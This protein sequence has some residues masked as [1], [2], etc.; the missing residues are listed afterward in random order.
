M[1]QSGLILLVY[2]SFAASAAVQ[3]GR[4]DPTCGVTGYDAG[5]EGYY[6]GTQGTYSTCSKKCLKDPKNCKSFSFGNKEC[7]LYDVV[8]AGNLAP[9]ADSP[10]TF[11]D[12]LCVAA[13][14]T[15]ST[16][17]TTT[18]PKQ[19][20]TTSSSNK[21][22]VTSSKSSSTTIKSTT[23]NGMLTTA[24]SS[25][26]TVVK[27]TSSS[28]STAAFSVSA[29]TAP[30]GPI[31][32]FTVSNFKWINST[33]NAD[34]AGAGP[35]VGDGTGCLDE[36]GAWCDPNLD[37]TCTHCGVG[38][39][40]TGLP[41]QPIGYGPSD[42]ISADIGNIGPCYQENP[43]TTPRRPIGDGSVVRC[44]GSQIQMSFKGD[45]N[46]AKSIAYF[47][48][49]NQI[50]CENRGYYT[51]YGS[52]SAAMSCTYDAGRNATCVLD[53]PDFGVVATQFN[54]YSG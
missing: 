23:S 52:G 19:T 21:P 47:N 40:F 50:F 54:N 8:V 35:D 16:T 1:R 44:G 48:F 53:D 31:P 32:T 24:K 10:Y 28:R 33:H 9:V 49:Q 45:S 38:V 7:N 15:S 2:A 5:T 14:A 43:G 6:Y 4:R 42:K 30:C 17:Q 13:A 46:Q 27:S 25:S 51:A 11:Y 37:K 34:C 39:C 12:A 36:N 26:T 3:N 41:T 18:I 29:Q 22:L 20:S